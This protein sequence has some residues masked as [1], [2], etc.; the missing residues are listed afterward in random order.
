MSQRI[1]I[2]LR[3]PEAAATAELCAEAAPGAAELLWG[4]LATPFVGR[5]AHAIYAGPAVLV[6]IP[7]RHGEPRGGQIPVENEA[8]RPRPGDILLL[9]PPTDEEDLGAEPAAHGVTVAIF[10]GDHGRPLTPQGWQPGVVVARVTEGLDGLREACR[11]VRFEGATEVTLARQARPGE[12]ERAVLYTDGASLGNPGPAGAGFVLT[13]DDGQLL[14]EG[15]VPL[16]PA[17]VNV[18]EYRALIAGLHEALR[19]GIRRLEARMDSELVIKQLKGR[20]RVKAEGLRPLYDWA[21][22]LIGRFDEFSCTHVPREENR[23]ADKLAGEAA[24]RS[25]EQHTRD[26]E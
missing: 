12:V 25:K 22:K 8:D 21:R 9:S 11:R 24:K 7:E 19:L 1:Q 26:V 2:T 4:I 3:E 6:T 14:A 13:A 18:A 15:S 16:E 10:Y 20:Y 17:T 5:A 23:R